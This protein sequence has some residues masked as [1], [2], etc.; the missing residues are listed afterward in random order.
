MDDITIMIVDDEE[1][2]L[3]GIKDTLPE[4]PIRTFMNPKAAADALSR[5]FYDIIVADYRMPDLSGLD[6]FIM[7]KQK[8]AY[9]YGI[10]LT[11]YADKELLR[12]FINNN[13]IQKVIE[14]PLRIDIFKEVLDEGVFHCI[15]K[16]RSAR[17]FHALKEQY[18]SMLKKSWFLND[19]I[20][21]IDGGLKEVFEKARQVAAVS[22]NVLITGE[23]GTGKEVMART[24]HSLG[25]RKDFPFIKINCGC[26][27]ETLMENELFGHVRGAYSDA[28]ADKQGKI[29]LAQGG[30]LFLDEIGELK[31][32]LQTRLLQVVQEKKIERIGSTKGI[33][34]DFRL[35][36]ATNQDLGS[37]LKTRRLREDLYYRIATF[38]LHLPP[39]R[40]RKEDIPPLIQYLL[41]KYREEFG[42]KEIS[43]GTGAL[44]K[45]LDYDWPG[46]IRELESVLK[47]AVSL[48]DRDRNEI[49]GAD[50]AQLDI[51]GAEEDID[52]VFDILTD[53][54]LKEETTIKEL[55]NRFLKRVL[56]RFEGKVY[57]AS[58]RTGIPKDRFYRHVKE[59]TSY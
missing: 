42:R 12:I 16:K 3:E 2:M 6:F 35:L 18:E 20:I 51:S 8:E 47:R 29:E 36:S 40:E 34:V 26:I 53:E 17:E 38:H 22:E 27:P 50:I 32:E 39:L 52:T 45:M 57:E 14:K 44:I 11:A 4:Y 48:L 49:S 55:E 10:L 33:H 19:E 25:N 23:T 30:T 59:K 31:P 56:E 1:A 43:I 7:A 9:H 46:N 24:I 28:Y 13:L 37:L 21:G 41:D 15:Q 5:G 54:L 58:K